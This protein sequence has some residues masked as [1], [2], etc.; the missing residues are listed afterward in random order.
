MTHAA[1]GSIVWPPLDLEIPS[2]SPAAMA[3]PPP[4]AWGA[5]ARA[6]R[7]MLD[8]ST[9]DVGGTALA[10]LRRQARA[11]I[12]ALAA[13]YTHRLGV[14]VGST[15]TRLSFVTGH[16]PLL[17]H[18]GIW[19]K[20]LALARLVP[21]G[22]V[23]LNLVVDSDAADEVAADIPRHDGH[24]RRA[25]V[26][27]ARGGSN[28][29][30]EAIPEPDAGAWQRFA[31]EIDA[32]L[33]TLRNPELLEGWRRARPLFPP[34]PG[35]GLAGALTALRRALEGPR[36]YLDLPVSWLSRTRAFRRFVFA[37]LRDAGRFALIHN[38]CLDAYRE[39]YGVRTAAQP[40]PD[41]SMDGER[42]E[43]PFWYVTEGQRWPLYADPPGGRLVAGDR[44]VGSI[45]GDPDDAAFVEV[46]LR[47]RALTLTAFARLVLADL[48]VHGVGGGR[49]DRAT[50][51]VMH[52]FLGVTP[53]AYAATTATLFLPFGEAGSRE[54]ERQRLHR[55]L[56]DLQHNPDR[57]LAPEDG[58]HRALIEEKWA[59]I[60]RLERA[61]ELTRK[62][63]RHATQRI[64][65]LNTILQVEVAGRVAEAQEGLDRL[66][67]SEADAGV[68]AYRGYPFVL[69]R[70][71]D[72]EALVDLLGGAAPPEH[73]GAP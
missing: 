46:P 39:H 66:S 5:L 34:V 16:Q 58:A 49:Y 54:A 13:D 50:D 44:D 7:D 63:R 9:V 71:E 64:R 61:G 67:R 25:R 33:A 68:T 30:I 38:V 12:L 17:V 32:H 27:L 26:P 10:D 28:V 56:L 37:V 52:A 57:F 19:I 35:L 62:E 42:I 22:D 36:P 73:R 11:E 21:P 47:P 40:F 1:V 45:P 41:L 4:A 48:F 60:K 59:L 18:P 3:V 8:G 53:P 51:A 6:N 43:V 14:P 2:D 23:G 29:P 20:Y 31:G 72:V 69:H 15:A 65:E 24:L 70:I 55:L